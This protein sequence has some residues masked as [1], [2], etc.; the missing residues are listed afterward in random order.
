MIKRSLTSFLDGLVGWVVGWFSQLTCSNAH[1]SHTCVKSFHFEFP[2]QVSS[3]SVKKWQSYAR[4][5]LVGRQAS[6][7]VGWF[8][9]INS[10][11]ML[12]SSIQKLHTKFQPNWL[13]NAKVM[14]DFLFQAGRL[15]RWQASLVG[16]HAKILTNQIHMLS[17]SIQ[18]LYTKFQP[19]WLKNAKVMH[20]FHFKAG[21]LVGWQ[22][23]LAGQHVKIFIN[24]NHMLSPSIQRLHTKFPPNQLK[25]A[26]VMHVFHFQAGRLVGWQAGLAGQH[27]KI[28]T[29]QIHMLSPSIRDYIP[30]FNLIG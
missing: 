28:F 5:S 16:Q 9:R 10:V 3:K 8:D 1:K 13:K 17:P 24:R 21:R 30:S 12:S 25:N 2:Y 11:H 23:G 14:Q 22:S 27:A 26:K 7:V 15:V 4:F 29:N 18:R 19:N 20:V 6:W